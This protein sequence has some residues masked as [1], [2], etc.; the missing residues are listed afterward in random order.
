[1]PMSMIKKVLRV[2]GK[3]LQSVNLGGGEPTLH[4]KFW[5]VLGLC[6]E[7]SAP[8]VWL[9]TNGKNTKRTKALLGI[10][11]ER[12]TVT[13]SK[14]EW[15]EPID[16]SIYKICKSLCAEIR[17][18]VS[19]V[20]DGLAKDNGIGN[21]SD[22]CCSAMHV[23]VNGDIKFCG[24]SDAPVLLNINDDNFTQDTIKCITNMSSKFGCLTHWT[25]R[26]IDKLINRINK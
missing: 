8:Q 23:L 20:K 4:S 16:P 2:G 26:D 21:T 18:N 5:E 17:S 10:H 22:C 24:C 11:R 6:L 12:F 3:E 19:I 9:A 7:T 1:M 15:H 13:V 14:D 25:Q